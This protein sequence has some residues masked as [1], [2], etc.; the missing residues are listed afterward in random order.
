MKATADRLQAV[1]EQSKTPE[2]RLN[3]MEQLL[4]I[5]PTSFDRQITPTRNAPNTFA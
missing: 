2:L 4:G 3:R 5:T 1:T